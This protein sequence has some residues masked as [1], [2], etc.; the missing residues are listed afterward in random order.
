MTNWIS[1]ADY[2]L[3]Y[4][5]S[6][7]TLSR[8]IKH[9]LVKARYEKGKY[10]IEDSDEVVRSLHARRVGVA[11]A[12]SPDGRAPGERLDPSALDKELVQKLTARAASDPVVKQH[13]EQGVT[14][15]AVFAAAEAGVRLGL[16]AKLGE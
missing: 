15:L 10:Y 4:G 12:P 3:K 13:L 6:R 8:R 5:V 7:A 14:T 2:V 1:L 9:K 16:A 11:A